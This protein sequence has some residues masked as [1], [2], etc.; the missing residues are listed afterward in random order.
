MR[1]TVVH[2]IQGNIASIAASPKDSPVMYVKLVA[3]QRVAEIDAPELKQDYVSAHLSE[4]IKDH[5][6]A[7]EPTGGKLVKIGSGTAK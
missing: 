5:R 1:L 4:L 6:V 7:I 3:G 2:D